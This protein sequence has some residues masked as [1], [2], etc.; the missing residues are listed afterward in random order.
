MR[1]SLDTLSAQIG[2]QIVSL[3]AQENSA[4]VETSIYCDSSLHHN[5]TGH[6]FEE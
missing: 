3:V 1:L 6:L 4:M 2:F 5:S